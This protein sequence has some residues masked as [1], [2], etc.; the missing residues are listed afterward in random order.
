MEEKN[1]IGR[2]LTVDILKTNALGSPTT[3]FLFCAG[4]ETASS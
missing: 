3:P 2:I 4:S 1:V